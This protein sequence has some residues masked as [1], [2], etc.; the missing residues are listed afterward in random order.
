MTFYRGKFV[1][2]NGQVFLIRDHGG[3]GSG[4]FG[5]SG[6][7]GEVEQARESEHCGCG[8]FKRRE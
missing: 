1:N 6:R 8:E 2:V 5:H 3:E 4:N 7:P